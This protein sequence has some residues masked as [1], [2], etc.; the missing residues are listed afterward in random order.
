[1]PRW[2]WLFYSTS[3]SDKPLAKMDLDELRAGPRGEVKAAM[4]DVKSAMESRLVDRGPR[5]PP[6]R[7]VGAIRCFEVHAE[8]LLLCVLWAPLEDDR[9]LVLLH[10][11]RCGSDGPPRAAYDLAQSR[12]GDLLT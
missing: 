11:C 6:C 4:W 10:I 3:A 2:K 12:L 7:R 8:T 5:H 1:M 9:T